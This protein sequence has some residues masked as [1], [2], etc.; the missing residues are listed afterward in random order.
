MQ[1]AHNMELR[2]CFRVTGGGSLKGFFQGQGVSTG[3]IFFSSKRAQ[4]AGC[5]ADIGGIDVAVYVEVGFVAVQPFPDMIG[6]PAQCENVAGAIKSYGIRRVQA[7]A[8]EYLF[9]NGIEM[10]I[11][12]LE[13]VQIRHHS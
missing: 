2:D 8:G 1:A 4:S 11:I 13:N 6:Q 5:N 3:G 7:L 10:R 9:G 12:G